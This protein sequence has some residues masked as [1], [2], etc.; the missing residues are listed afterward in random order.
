MTSHPD[1]S[2][3]VAEI[4]AS[5]KR[6]GC[7]VS[8]SIRL[9]G[10]EFE[11]FPI[12]LRGGRYCGPREDKKRAR[13]PGSPAT[14]DGAPE[15]ETADRGLTPPFTRLTNSGRRCVIF[16]TTLKKREQISIRLWPGMFIW[17]CWSCVFLT[18]CIKVYTQYFGPSLPARTTVQQIAPTERKPDKDDHFQGLE[19]VSLIAVPPQS[20][21][22]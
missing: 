19:Q 18:R 10:E 22:R 2:P 1:V 4:C 12:A 14:R 9:Y 16:S 20:W 17:L 21:P 6:L 7:G 15:R 13:N 11:V 3:S 5:V 8:Q